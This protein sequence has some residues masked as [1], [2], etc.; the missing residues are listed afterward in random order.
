M[1]PDRTGNLP[2]LIGAV[3]LRPVITIHKKPRPLAI[4]LLQPDMIVMLVLNIINPA[5]WHNLFASK[6][7]AITNHLANAKK[8][9]DRN[10]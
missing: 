2:G 6:T 4:L 1:N 3:P 10:A 8:I 9:M 5:L 7:A